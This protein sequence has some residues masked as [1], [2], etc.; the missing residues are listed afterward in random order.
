MQIWWSSGLSA[1]SGLTYSGTRFDTLFAAY[2]AHYGMMDM[3]SAGFYP[4][5]TLEEKWGY[6][7]KHIYH[8]RYQTGALSLYRDLLEVVKD[9]DYFVITTNVDGQ[10]MKAGFDDQRFFEVQGNYGE[11]Q[12]SVPCQQTVYGNEAMVLKMMKN[13]HDLK[14]SSEL[15]PHCPNCGAPLTLHLRI[16]DT[17]VED[18]RWQD[19]SQRYMDF[20][21]RIGEQKVVFIELGV[22][23]NTPTI[24]RYPFEKMAAVLPHAKL[25]RVNRDDVEGFMENADKTISLNQDMKEVFTTWQAD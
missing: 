3:Y 10:F 4:F 8:N 1:A 11:W 7:V 5:S 2:K 24:V 17:F 12:C 23:Y 19:M 9:K 13:I 18:E 21:Q 22:G 6:W 20:L 25:I 14:I 16:D 15:V